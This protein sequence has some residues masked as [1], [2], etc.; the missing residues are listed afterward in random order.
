MNDAVKI[1]SVKKESHDTRTFSFRWE[2]DCRPGQF[3]MVWIP[4]TDEIPMSLSS[5]EGEKSI[6]VK[7]IGEATRKLHELRKDDILHIRGP[8]GNG[9]A[10]NSGEK[11]LIVAGGVGM[12]AVMPM[13]R[14]TGADTVLGARTSGELIFEEEASSHSDIRVSTDDGSRGSRGNAVQLAEQRLSEKAYDIVIGCGPE[15]MLYH[16][17]RLCVKQNVK[18]QLSL[19]RYMKCGAG[20]CGSCM[21]NTARVCA[22]GPVFTGEQISGMS[23]FGRFKRDP[24][25]LL[26]RL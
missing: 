7:A 20:V 18:C 6:T 14:A 11:I 26:I 24:S 3:V 9:F 12:A 5:T 13:I 21:M 4:G 22:D 16:L 19:E 25:G 23:E 1:T 8:Y 15:V 10:V 2:K 17:H